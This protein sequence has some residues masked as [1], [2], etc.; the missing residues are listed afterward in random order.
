LRLQIVRLNLPPELHS[1]IAR[2]L[3]RL[4]VP[5]KMSYVRGGLCCGD[6]WCALDVFAHP[7]HRIREAPLIT[8]FPQAHSSRELENQ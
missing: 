3:L 2:D 6:E 8:D 7:I 5:L 4:Q 1:R